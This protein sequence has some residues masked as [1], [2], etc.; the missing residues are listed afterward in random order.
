MGCRPRVPG[1]GPRPRRSRVDVY[2]FESVD[3]PGHWARLDDFEGSGYQRV[4]TTVHTRTGQVRAFIY[5]SR[6]ADAP[7]PPSIS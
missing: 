1:P 6:P 4:L 5:A 2:V 3:L 7:A